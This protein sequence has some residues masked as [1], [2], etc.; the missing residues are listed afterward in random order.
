MPENP[1]A[2][3]RRAEINA[4]LDA[5]IATEAARHKIL[6]FADGLA[7]MP[8]ALDQ[9]PLKHHF[10]PGVY[11]RE[12]FIPRGV[13]VV[14]AIHRHAHMN[15]IAAGTCA[16]FTE[17]AGTERLVAPHT[18]VSKVGTKRIVLAIEDTIWLTVHENADNEIDTDK[19]V[20][21]LTVPTYDALLNFEAGPPL[22]LTES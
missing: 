5:E 11:T 16:V 12:I 13:C 4:I 8:S 10:S 17:F 7:Q 3:S 6:N 18:F 19:L 2:I 14:G 20:D 9:L 21:R 1:I 15:I 22:A